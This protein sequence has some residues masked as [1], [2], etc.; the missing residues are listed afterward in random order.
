[1][2]REV[3]LPLTRTDIQRRFSGISNAKSAWLLK[4]EPVRVLKIGGAS[5]VSRY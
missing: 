4:C 3:Q 2:T 1:M 5:R